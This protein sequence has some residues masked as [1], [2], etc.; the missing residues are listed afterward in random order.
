MT[1]ITYTQKKYQQAYNP[2]ENKVSFETVGESMTQTQFQDSQEI[3]NIIRAF[4][5]GLPITVNQ[6]SATYD[7]VSEIQD[8]SRNFETLKNAQIIKKELDEKLQNE[9]KQKQEN[10]Q[11]QLKEKL[12]K[13]EKYENDEKNKNN[14]Q[15]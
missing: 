9:Q 3:S 10:E 4:T 11:K 15:T 13:L 1:N 6:L 12:E 5:K 8:Y 7:D 2:P 14:T